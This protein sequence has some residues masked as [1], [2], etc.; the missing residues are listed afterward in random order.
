MVRPYNLFG[1]C[2]R[3]QYCQLV[4][5]RQT[6]RQQFVGYFYCSMINSASVIPVLIL[7]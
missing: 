1:D 5:V 4:E 6:H 2:F 7:N 3:L